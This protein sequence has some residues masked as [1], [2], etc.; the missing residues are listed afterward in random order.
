MAKTGDTNVLESW[1]LGSFR[2]PTTRSPVQGFQIREVVVLPLEA[3]NQVQQVLQLAYQ[4]SDGEA[5][6]LL[7]HVLVGHDMWLD[8]LLHCRCMADQVRWVKGFVYL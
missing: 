4:I 1:E 5:H 3:L 8:D 6:G 7:P 2:S